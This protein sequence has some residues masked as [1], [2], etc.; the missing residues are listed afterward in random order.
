MRQSEVREEKV[1]RP[2]PVKT[3]RRERPTATTKTWRVVRMEVPA[4]GGD[5][6]MT[7]VSGYSDKSE[8]DCRL[9]AGKMNEK[10]KLGEDAPLISY[11]AKPNA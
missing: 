6:N 4:G 9:K 11:V 10:V 8:N 7:T 1:R 3:P 5:T 2:A